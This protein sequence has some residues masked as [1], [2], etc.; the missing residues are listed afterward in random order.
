[1]RGE[2][3]GIKS[4][5]QRQRLEEEIQSKIQPRWKPKEELRSPRLAGGRSQE[6]AASWA[7]VVSRKF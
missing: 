6:E 5:T 2:G 7:R 4:V 1:M 3:C